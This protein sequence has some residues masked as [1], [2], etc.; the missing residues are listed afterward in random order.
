MSD[1]WD[2]G[3]MLCGAKTILRQRNPCNTRVCAQHING[4]LANLGGTRQTHARALKCRRAGRADSA[5]VV[6]RA[7]D[8]EHPQRQQLKRQ[9]QARTIRSLCG[10]GH[11]SS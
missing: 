11:H 2:S 6:V 9:K 5:E 3:M 4:T 8:R 10:E 1:A 7:G